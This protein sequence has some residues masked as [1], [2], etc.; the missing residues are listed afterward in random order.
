MQKVK[1]ITED[2]F[3]EALLM[4]WE[5][6]PASMHHAPNQKW[7][8]ED[9]YYNLDSFISGVT[10]VLASQKEPVEATPAHGNQSL[11]LERDPLVPGLFWLWADDKAI[12]IAADNLR[13]DHDLKLIYIDFDPRDVSEGTTALRLWLDRQG[14]GNWRTI[15]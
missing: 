9:L 3:F 1:H 6:R 7:H 13:L 10:A 5:A 4:A 2:E 11:N 14:R 15:T 8:P 12:Q